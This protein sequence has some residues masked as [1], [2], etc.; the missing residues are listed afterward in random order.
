M[1]SKIYTLGGDTKQTKQDKE[2][3][4]AL[5]ETQNKEV[6]EKML[7]NSEVHTEDAVKAYNKGLMEPDPR[8]ENIVLPK[9]KV[10]LSLFRAPRVL[11]SGIYI[12][13]TET[14]INEDTGR[15]KLV[16]TDN[17]T[18]I[19]YLS[20]GVVRAVGDGCEAHLKPGTVVDLYMQSYSNIMQYWSP[21]DRNDVNQKQ[22]EN[23]FTIPET[24]INFTWT[25]YQL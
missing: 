20:R 9:G 25:T 5:K 8:L 18:E 1:A 22:P 6:A 11:A 15:L 3:I 17:P 12:P 16:K 23:F 10:L 4:K 2:Q 14:S 7:K 21:I 19:K 13:S 24:Y